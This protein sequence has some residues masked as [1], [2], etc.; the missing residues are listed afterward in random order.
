[1]NNLKKNLFIL[2]PM[3]V[4]LSLVA[5]LYFG[6]NM[7]RQRVSND[8]FF[9]END[10]TLSDKLREV[11]QYIESDYVDT[12]KEEMLVEGA[13]NELLQNLDPHSFY[14][15]KEQYAAVNDPLEGNFEGIGI[16]FRIQKDTVVVVQPIGGG[17]SEKVGIRA[18]DR[19]VAVEGENITGKKLN[20]Q[21]VIDLLKG[22][23]GTEVSMKVKRHG[24][25]DLIK[26]TVVRDEIPLH[27]VETSYMVDQV[28]YIKI[29]R[30]S[31]TTYDEFM[32]AAE[33]LKAKGMKAL[34]VDLRN[35]GGG[36]LLSA[37]KIADEFLKDGKLI[38]YTE[39][40]SRERQEFYASSDGILEN[41][42]V[43]IL[44][45][46]GSASASEILAGAIQD[47]DRGE[48]IG[49]RSFGKGL[50]QEGI[51]WPDGS[52]MRLT[53][54][55]YYTPVGR[56]IQKP[57]DDGLQA[58][59]SEAYE[60]FEQGELFSPDSI[61]FIDSLRYITNGGDTVYG[62]GGIMPDIF[63]PIDTEGTTHY[64]GRLNYSG[65]FY[66]YGFYYV[67]MHRD[68]LKSEFNEETY[69]RNFSLDQATLSDFYS[70]AEKKG[71]EYDRESAEASLDLIKKMLKATIGRNLWGETIFYQV[72]NQK[73]STFQRAIQEL[74]QT[75]YSA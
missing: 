23:K 20:N 38:V 8:L 59:K 35:N 70:Y 25:D 33:H 37:T 71:I 68:Q 31:K 61:H 12:I 73:D 36:Y 57:F 49:R 19:I 29:I 58:Y 18:G 44:I 4:A 66:L 47:N 9:A 27:S 74:K 39:G 56:S 28:G 51:Q 46:E 32:N 75:T 34:I 30:F 24:E 2:L 42:E 22:P 40:K 10:F 50:V 53:V 26:F 67:D 17:P 16:E 72:I 45:N 11:I 7:S 1:M 43:A 65:L 54:A 48:I 15:P 64:F 69:L 41:M 3:I 62:G 14:I 13:I 6:K 55:R 63:I 21:L 52:A 5:G 60:R